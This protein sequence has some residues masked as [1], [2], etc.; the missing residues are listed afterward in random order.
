MNKHIVPWAT[1]IADALENGRDWDP[2]EVA[3]HLRRLSAENDAL[4]E[5]NEAFAKRQ[6]WWNEKMFQREEQTERDTALL[7]QALEALVAA[8][9]SAHKTKQAREKAITALRERLEGKA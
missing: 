9:L 5:A 8:G 7:L 3:A 4:R 2:I 6:E 1:T